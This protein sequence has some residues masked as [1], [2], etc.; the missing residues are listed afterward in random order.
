MPAPICFHSDLFCMKWRLARRPSRETRT[1]RFM[2][3][4]CI[5]RQRPCENSIRRFH[6]GWI[7]S[8]GKRPKRTVRSVTDRLRRFAAIWNS[9]ARRQARQAHGG[10]ESGLHSLSFSRRL[11]IGATALV[12]RFRHSARVEPVAQLK[13]RRSLAVLGFRNLSNKPDQDWIA[14]ALAEMVSTELAAGQQLRII[15]SENVA[16]M[17]LDLALDAPGGYG[18]STLERIQQNLGADLIVSGFVFSITG[19]RFTRRL[20]IAGNRYGRNDRCSLRERQR[21]SGCRSGL[22]RRSFVAHEVRGLAQHHPRNS[23]RLGLLCLPIRS[24]LSSTPRHSQN[25]LPLTHSALVTS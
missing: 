16:H 15:P 25:H 23:T 5:G 17:K 4:F 18:P 14:T 8:S 1:P 9:C 21:S 20:A 10:A 2:M 12:W 11:A 22:A 3:P 6:P 7:G 13:P 24:P 19:S